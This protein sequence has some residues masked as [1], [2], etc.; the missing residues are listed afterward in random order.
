MRIKQ[1][2]SIL[3]DSKVRGIYKIG[4]KFCAKTQFMGKT[5]HLGTFESEEAA[6]S[7]YRSAITM[8]LVEYERMLEEA[9]QNFCNENNEDK[10]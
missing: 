5:K 2:T 6:N 3:L 1:S 9:L 4:S 10:E 7:A 8:N